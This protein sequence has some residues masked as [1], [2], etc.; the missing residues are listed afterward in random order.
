V[1]RALPMRW[2]ISQRIG[3]AATPTSIEPDVKSIRPSSCS[4]YVM[5]TPTRVE[6]AAVSTPTRKRRSSPGAIS[7]HLIGPVVE[8]DTSSWL[9]T[10]VP[11]WSSP[12]LA[13]HRSSYSADTARTTSGPP[14]PNLGRLTPAARTLAGKTTPSGSRGRH[15]S[16]TRAEAWEPRTGVRTRDGLAGGE[17]AD[18]SG[19]TS[20]A[21]MA[22]ILQAPEEN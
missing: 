21:W 18:P 10:A 19:H 12:D 8:L 16:R 7:A 1:L 3:N 5:P 2:A 4:V 6:P 14:R 15:R 20:T 11:S 22:E 13:G 9:G 17:Y